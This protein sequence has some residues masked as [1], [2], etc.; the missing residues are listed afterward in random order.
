M[1][2]V[3]ASDLV[4]YIIFLHVKHD[5]SYKILSM[6][7]RAIWSMLQPTEHT[8]VPIVWQLLKGIFRR[9][10]LARV[11]AETWDVKKVIDLPHS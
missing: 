7:A 3:C 11:W 2:K 4:M 10:P 6:H 5:Y 8:S 9:N 1:F